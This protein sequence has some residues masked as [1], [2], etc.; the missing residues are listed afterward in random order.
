MQMKLPLVFTSH[1]ASNIIWCHK[2]KGYK[3][4]KTI[5]CIVKEQKHE[6]VDRETTR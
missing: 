2:Y 4:S 3:T 1:K 6:M 5:S